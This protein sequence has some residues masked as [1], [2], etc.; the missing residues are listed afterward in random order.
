MICELFPFQKQAVNE[1]RLRVAMALNN[2][3]MLKIPQV[4]SLQAP[5]GSGKTI[6]MSALIEDI[7]YGSE[8][9]TEQPEAIFVWLSDSPQLNE[10]SKQKIELKADKIRMDQCVVIS[11][12]SFDRE[13]LEDGHIYFLNTQKLGKAG[14]LSRHSDTRQYTIWETI[15]NT[16]REKADRLYFIIDEAHRGMQGRQAGTA[17]TIMQRFIKGSSE[18]NLSP[19]PVVIGMSATAERFNSLVGQ[20]TNS[21]LHKVIISPAQVRQSGLL[22]DRIVITYPEDPIKHGDMAVLQAA[23]DEW[24]DKCKHWYQYT[25]EQHYT[26]V[27]PVFVIQVCAGSGTKVSDTDLDDVIA[28]IEERMGDS[29]KENEVVHTFGSTGTLSIHGLTVPHIEPSEIAEDRR[30][31]VVLF[32]EN[33]S[34]GWDCPRAETMMSFRRA[35]DATYI[36]Q[37]LGRMVRTPLQCHVLVDDSLNDVRLFLPYFNQDTVQKVI[38]ELQATEGGE[39]PTVVDGESLEE[40]NYDTWSVHNQRKKTQKLTVGQLSIFDYPNGF[41]EEPAVASSTAVGDMPNSGVV[42]VNQGR[43]DSELPAEGQH[44]TI[45][46][47]TVPRNDVH[48]GQEIERTSEGDQSEKKEQPVLTPA[49]SQM[50][51]LPTIDREGITKF[52]NEQGYLTYI[53]RAVKINSYLKSLMSL[54]GLLSQFNICI[55]AAEDVKNDVAELIRNY[56]NGLHDAG[57]YDELTKQVMEMKLSVQIFDVFGEKIQSDNQ[58]DMFTASE[59]DLD[60][61]LRVADAKMG[62]CG[63]HLAYG[64]KYIDFDNPNAFKVDCILFAFDSECI[65]EL[66]KYAEK[67][68]HELNDQYRKYIVAKPEK[69][70]KQYS[71]IVANGD[72]IS[73]HNFTLP[74]TI[75]A[76]VEADGIKYTDHLFANADG[77]AKI[78]LNGWEQAVLAEEQKRE[79]YVCW[80]RNPSRQS[81]SLRMPYEMDGKCK[82]LYPD[83]IIVRQDPILKY[84]VDIL[85]PH[86]PDFK[87]NLGKATIELW[88]DGHKRLNYNDLPDEL[89]THKNRKSFLDRFKVVEGDEAYC[90]TMLAHISKD[91][92]YFIHPDIEQHRSI[93]VREAARIQSFPDDYFFEGPR[94]AQFVQIGNAVP[95]L[96]AKGIAEGIANELSKEGIDGK[97]S[98]T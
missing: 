60:R 90:H 24:Q 69:C 41:Q 78:K 82:E 86:N 29:F 68:F 40:Q 52:I 6:I 88:N 2:Y 28:K 34:T 81:W 74:E 12:E 20:A 57:K 10:Q 49:V 45:P 5:T 44:Q 71:D 98:P 65:A 38:D 83:F 46:L 66:N 21:T 55:T 47:E 70:Q 48:A 91:G 37:L 75:S 14:N 63:F 67:K 73:K 27:N 33:L 77:I 32:K 4:V 93:T 1:M 80:L 42:A 23:T 43:V 16:A 59:S 64:R 87:D 8:Q 85:E 36:A 22:K 72:E 17:T 18:Q 9:F 62:G 26:N 96:M 30:I 56:V 35:E 51:M 13:I 15:E 79:D 50:S 25:Y 3:R 39:I 31:R 92:H 7:F 61:Q 53:V 95:T 11:D 54:A 19:I 89:K 94:T 97:Q 76:K 84:I 58:I